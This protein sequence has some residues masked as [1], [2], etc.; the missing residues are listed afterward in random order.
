MSKLGSTTIAPVSVLLEFFLLS[1]SFLVRASNASIIF[2]F[3]GCFTG[4]VPL[5]SW[6][7]VSLYRYQVIAACAPLKR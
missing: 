1:T 6:T 4:E 3:V 7:L 5:L 2:P